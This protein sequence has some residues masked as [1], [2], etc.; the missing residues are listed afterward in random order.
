L[1]TKNKTHSNEWVFYY[2]RF[3]KKLLKRINLLRNFTM[4]YLILLMALSSTLFT[5][6]T[7]ELN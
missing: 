2:L 7:K 1:P 5:S 3:L 4:K 6:C